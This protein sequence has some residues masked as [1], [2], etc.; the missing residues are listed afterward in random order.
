MTENTIFIFESNSINS[1]MKMYPCLPSSGV[2][3]IKILEITN[4][5]PGISL[6]A[7]QF[8]INCTAAGVDK[9]GINELFSPRKKYECIHK[10][11][12]KKNVFKLTYVNRRQ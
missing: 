6:I 5:T 12:T 3:K 9:E 1:I 4:K 2:Y 10:D 7:W 8:V 11:R